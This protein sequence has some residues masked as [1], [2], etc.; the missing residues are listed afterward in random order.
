MNADEAVI[1]FVNMVR[2]GTAAL[3]QIIGNDPV[4]GAELEADINQL[5]FLVDSVS[6]VGENIRIKAHAIRRSSSSLG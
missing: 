1:E 5:L 3:R 2:L 4:L 6:D